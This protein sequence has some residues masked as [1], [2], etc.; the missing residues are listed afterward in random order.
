MITIQITVPYRFPLSKLRFRLFQNPA[1]K[2]QFFS[3]NSEYEDCAPEGWADTYGDTCQEYLEKGHCSGNYMKYAKDGYHGVHCSECGCVVSET[4]A[5][6][7]VI[8][9]N[10]LN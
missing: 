5:G 2:S 3:I 7:Y 8:F 9:E 10:A 6:N 4:P 1:Y